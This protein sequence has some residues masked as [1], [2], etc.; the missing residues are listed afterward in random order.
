M[1]HAAEKKSGGSGRTVDS[2]ANE[3]TQLAESGDFHRA[4]NLREYLLANHPTALSA[5]IS[6]AEIIEE[7][8]TL[9]IDHDHLATWDELYSSLSQEEQNCLF[10]STKGHTVPARKLI[11]RQGRVIPRLLFVDSGK[12]T[13]FHT[14]GEERILLGQLSGGDVLGE[15]TFF[16]LSTPTFSA[17]AQTEVRLRYLD[18]SVTRGWEERQP[19]LYQKLA[20]YFL[21]NSRAKQLLQQ[22]NIEKRLF[23][24][25]KVEGKVLAH[26]LSEDGSRTGESVRGSLIDLSRNGISFDIH[27]AK[28]ETAEALLGSMLDLELNF[29]GAGDGRAAKLIGNVV[30]VG[31]LLHNDYIINI[32]LQSVLSPQEFE[33]YVMT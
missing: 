31:V 10:Y 15:E 17:G 5:I 33:R 4:E 18:K 27:C 12:V 20:D 25:E 7:Q 28:S 26:V 21:R 6:T 13:L 24:R 19:G 29:V 3:I 16:S 8:K 32:Q 30:K 9:R 23:A 2:L 22:K 1:E 11:I 14:K